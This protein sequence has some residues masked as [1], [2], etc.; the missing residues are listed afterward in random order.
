MHMKLTKREENALRAAG[1][2]RGEPDYMR[3]AQ[4][5]MRT[6]TPEQAEQLAL[7]LEEFG[8]LVRYERRWYFHKGYRAAKKETE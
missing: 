7:A 5:L 1:E 4:K 8:A 3:A 6:L 2:P